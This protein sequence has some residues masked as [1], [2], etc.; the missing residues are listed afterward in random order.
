LKRP[1]F[2]PAATSRKR[3]RLLEARR[4]DLVMAMGAGGVAVRRLNGNTCHDLPWIGVHLPLTSRLISDTLPSIKFRE[5]IFCGKA[6]RLQ[7]K[8]TL[9][10]RRFDQK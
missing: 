7:Y 10:D 2:L 8:W 9:P 1:I 6:F 3:D 4:R 5:T